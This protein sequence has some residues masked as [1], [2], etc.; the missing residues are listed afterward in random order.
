MFDSRLSASLQCERKKILK[1]NK[2]FHML[3]TGKEILRLQEILD[4]F[5]RK[6]A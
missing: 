6:D 1:V 3:V 2:E 5:V 4:Y